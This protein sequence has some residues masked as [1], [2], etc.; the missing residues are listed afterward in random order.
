MAI[1]TYSDLKSTIADW[2]ERG[3]LTSVIPTFIQLAE[4][5]INAKFNLRDGQQ[6]TTLTATSGSRFI[7][8]PTGFREGCNL[9]INWSYGRGD[10]LRF[11]MPELLITFTSPGV[12]LTWCIDGSNIAFEKPC[13]DAFSMTLRQSTGETLSDANPSNLLLALYPNVYLFGALKEAA[14]YLKDDAGLSK[15]SA[16]YELALDDA[17]YKESRHSALVTLSTEPGII[18]LGNRRG[19]NITRG[20]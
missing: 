12:P 9:W 13:S 14:D 16:R 10:P 8:L 17:K 5:D 11:V 1:S 15:W 2:L 3:D 4:A 7:P 18:Q 6:N 19:F 20:F